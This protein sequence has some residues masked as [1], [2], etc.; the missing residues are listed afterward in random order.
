MHQLFSL[1][2]RSAQ[3]TRQFLRDEFCFESFHDESST[4]PGQTAQ[5]GREPIEAVRHGLEDPLRHG[6][7][8]ATI[9]GGAGAAVVD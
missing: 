1:Y 3:H 4:V 2:L 7:E 8:D 9:A 6:G 5:Q